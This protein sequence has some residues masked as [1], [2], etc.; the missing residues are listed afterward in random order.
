MLSLIISLLD[1]C[2]I[3]QIEKD[4][5]KTI[6]IRVRIIRIK[7]I[8]VILDELHYYYLNNK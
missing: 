3:M 4:L 1:K 5:I 7:I 8:R 6:I 2:L